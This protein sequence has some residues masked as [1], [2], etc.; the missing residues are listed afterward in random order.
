[1]KRV[2]ALAVSVL[3]AAG[4]AAAQA[5]TTVRVG[6][7]DSRAVALAYYRSPEQARWVA[8]L[9]GDIERATAAHDDAHAKELEARGSAR[10]M[11]MHQQV[12]SNGSVANIAAAIADRLPPLAAAAGVTMVVSEWELSYCATSVERVDLTP[13]IVALFNPDDATRKLLNQMKGQSPISLMD[14]LAIKDWD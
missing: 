8:G 5:P 1:M 12:F 6:T 10:Q 7:F 13:Q 11:L 2:V 14:A 3:A 9:K 4:A